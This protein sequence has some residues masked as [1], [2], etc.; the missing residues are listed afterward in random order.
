MTEQIQSLLKQD[1]EAGFVTRVDSDTFAPG[2][3]EEVVRRI[4]A[5]KGEPDWL[6]EWRL[7]ALSRPWADATGVPGRIANS[8][9]A[10]PGL[11]SSPALSAM[12]VMSGP[13][14]VM[15]AS[16]ARP[17]PRADTAANAERT[18]AC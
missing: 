8:S 1:Y 11:Q 5:R 16:R 10:I 13:N 9:I 17:W 18:E 7:K 14:L 6:L 3:D 12:A 4:S 15:T 2:L